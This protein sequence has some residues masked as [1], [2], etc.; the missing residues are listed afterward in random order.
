MQGANPPAGQF[1]RRDG[2][3]PTLPDAKRIRVGYGPAGRFNDRN[4]GNDG[5]LGPLLSSGRE[6]GNLTDADRLQSTQTSK[7]LAVNTVRFFPSIFLPPLDTGKDR[8]RLDKAFMP[9]DIVFNLRCNDRMVAKRY[10]LPGGS[11]GG[12][13]LLYSVNLATVNYLLTGLQTFL[14]KIMN[15]LEDGNIVPPPQWLPNDI[16]HA[17]DAYL[18][19]NQENLKAWQTFFKTLMHDQN[20]G[21]RE[22]GFNHFLLAVVSMQFGL[23][24]TLYPAN[25][26][27]LAGAYAAQAPA[28]P[29]ADILKVGTRQLLSHS[30]TPPDDPSAQFYR[31]SILADICW[32]F[33]YSYCRPTGVFIGSDRQGGEDLEAPNP[34]SYAPNDYVGVVQVAGKNI[35]TANL[36]MFAEK[37]DH[38]V[39]PGDELGFGLKY[40]NFADPG[41]G[42]NDAQTLHFELSSNPRTG[43][44][45]KKAEFMGFLLTPCI[46]RCLLADCKQWSLDYPFSSHFMTFCIANQMSRR[47]NTESGD[48]RIA[49]NARL[50]QNSL[51][52]EVFLKFKQRKLPVPRAVVGMDTRPH[53]VGGGGG[54]GAPGGP[55][56]QPV[57]GV[58]GAAAN[59]MPDN[60]QVE[61]SG[62][63]GAGYP[64]MPTASAGASKT[65]TSKK[66]TAP[67]R[68]RVEE[69]D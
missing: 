33:I 37:K 39:N 4:T 34:C 59:V 17:I 10:V 49:C 40:H 55:P 9:G 44:A 36:W 19:N 1:N 8:V 52:L 21:R 38:A 65:K 56:N 16:I 68:T 51:P 50:W 69:T 28:N 23:A 53:Q 22:A 35:T 61:D 48:A 14:I 12:D 63:G 15:A 27:N 66:Q 64:P 46:Y 2:P 32:E 29:N 67:T 6:P 47:F 31:K 18:D 54:A 41:Q 26:G 62:A 11:A 25:H 57:Q 30:L 13:N 42:G 58:S 7:V 43:L 45:A 60:M 3:G 5:P 24:H 20:G